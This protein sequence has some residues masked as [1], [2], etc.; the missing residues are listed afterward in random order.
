LSLGTL[1]TRLLTLATGLTGRSV[2]AAFTAA[3][4][5]VIIACPCALGRA[6]STALMVG[7]GR[8]AQVAVLIKGAECTR[9]HRVVD[10]IVFDKTVPGQ[11]TD[12]LVL[13]ACYHSPDLV[14]RTV[15]DTEG[16][17]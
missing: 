5:V 16:Y 13:G 7:S 2:A 9:V 12:D 3:V 8:C 6:T 11:Q 1:A 15:R 14:D 10:I 17:H 4:A